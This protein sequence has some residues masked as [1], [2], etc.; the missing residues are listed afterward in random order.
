M[1]EEWFFQYLLECIIFNSVNLLS[2]ITRNRGYVTF[3][4]VCQPVVP[5]V[6]ANIQAQLSQQWAG[7]LIACF[8]LLQPH[9]ICTMITSSPS[10]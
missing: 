7:C 10:L 6:T 8:V 1:S 4:G 2:Q 3:V 5:A 9:R